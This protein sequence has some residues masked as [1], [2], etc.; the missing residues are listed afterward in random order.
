ME[1]LLEDDE[2]VL[3]IVMIAHTINVLNA[4]E[5]YILNAKCY[6]IYILPQL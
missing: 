4:I 2:K 5:L 1:F 6:V 3:E